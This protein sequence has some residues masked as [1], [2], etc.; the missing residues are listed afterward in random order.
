MLRNQGLLQNLKQVNIRILNLIIGKY[1][2]RSHKG[3]INTQGKLK[4]LEKYKPYFDSHD[5][6]DPSYR[7]I[8]IGRSKID[9][10]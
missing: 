1:K 7:P 4:L 10:N 6:S 3:D 2:P 9:K 8:L 5:L